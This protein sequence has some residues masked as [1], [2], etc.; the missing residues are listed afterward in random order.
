M[1]DEH[2][3]PQITPFDPNKTYGLMELARGRSLLVDKEPE[4]TV[5]TFP[6]L[7]VVE[8]LAAIAV[9]V[10]LLVLSFLRDAPLEE[11][12]NPNVPPSPAK[13]AWYLMGIQ[14][15]IL[16]LHP[17]WGAIIGPALAALAL[18]SIPYIDR[19]RDDLG[20]W[21]GGPRGKR[22]AG[23][24]ALGTFIIVP[25]LVALDS[26]VGL[27]SVFPGASILVASIIVPLATILGIV[28]LVF[29]I[30]RRMK[31]TTR[32]GAIAYVTMLVVALVVLTLI[33][34]VF[35]G[36]GMKLYWPWAMPAA[37]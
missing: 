19:S 23:I 32:E 3:D 29:V 16:H 2:Q 21:F 18:A 1:A 36:P 12:A 10:V 4:K 37:H 25:L 27:R 17:T 30:L 24:A 7:V 9:T 31:A 34:M 14:E 5:M 22:I 11:F 8:L 15:L 20:H 35:R 33:M 6:N 28:A 26:L 13:A